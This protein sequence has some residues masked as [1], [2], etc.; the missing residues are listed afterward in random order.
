MES[1][2]LG[3]INDNLEPR[4]VGIGAVLVL[5]AMTTIGIKQGVAQGTCYQRNTICHG[6][7]I[8]ETCL[9][10][11]REEITLEEKSECE[12]LSEIE[13]SCNQLKQRACMQGNTENWVES[14]T[15]SNLRCSR[16]IE[17]YDLEVER[18]R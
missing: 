13:E 18:C 5:L 8:G 4:F 12:E 15:T 1:L 17:G 2:K 11:Q 14:S 7:P 9:G 16:W 3:R 10:F 6:A